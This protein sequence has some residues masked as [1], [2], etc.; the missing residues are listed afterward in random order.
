MPEKYVRKPNRN[1]NAMR[2]R[3]VAT[4]VGG[5]LVAIVGTA[6]IGLHMPAAFAAD[7]VTSPAQK[8][9]QVAAGPLGPALMDFAAQAGINLEADLL[10][11]A[12][13]GMKLGFTGLISTLA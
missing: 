5:I 7:T 13:P 2:L 1:A 4:A 3:P 8:S 12:L 6:A 11:A 9:Y 10:I